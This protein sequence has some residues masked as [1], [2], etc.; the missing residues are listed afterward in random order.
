MI[1]GFAKW[2]RLGIEGNKIKFMFMKSNFG[3]KCIK[4]LKE[5]LE[6]RQ[7][8]CVNNEKVIVVEKKLIRHV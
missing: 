3:I 1:T 2:I 7:V 8:F 4:K 6:V 5:T